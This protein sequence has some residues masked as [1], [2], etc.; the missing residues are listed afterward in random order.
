MN[1]YGHDPY[2]RPPIGPG[3][4]AAG[5]QQAPP[6]AYY[7][8]KGEEGRTIGRLATWLIAL[9]IAEVVSGVLFNL[10]D[11]NA[12]HLVGGLLADVVVA[13]PIYR[14]AVAFDKVTKVHIH[15]VPHLLEGL[16]KLNTAL[17][18]RIFLE[19]IAIVI[20]ALVLLATIGM[21]HTET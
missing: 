18:V 11:F 21:L 7:E 5:G 20:L 17:W 2:G 3:Y 10:I 9:V 8:F 4:P 19:V 16:K 12:G 15:N 13:F 1:P 14:A 6:P